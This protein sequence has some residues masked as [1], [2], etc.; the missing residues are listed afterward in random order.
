MKDVARTAGVSVMT[1][2]RVINDTGSVNEEMAE[3]VR[4]AARQLAFEPNGV[5][6]DLRN[7]TE[8]SMI[9]LVI[10]DLANPFYSLL[11]KT[12]EGVAREHDSLLITASSEED[13]VREREVVLELA[14]RRVAGLIVVPAAGSHAFLRDQ[15]ELG[16]PAVLV[17]RLLADVEADAVL[18]DNFGGA[19]RG[20]DWLL[21]RG[22][23]SIAVLGFSDQIHSVA[24]RLEGVRV[25]LADRGLALDP[26]L[27]RLGALDERTAAQGM[28][29]LLD[30]ANPPSAVFCSNNRMTI[31]AIQ[32]VAR[33]NAQVDIVGFDD[34]AFAEF[35]PVPVVLITYDIER[36]AS[37]AA[38]LL[39]SRIKGFA[40][41]PRT[42]TVPTSLRVHPASLWSA[43]ATAR[44]V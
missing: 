43:A 22:H 15:V 11:A 29:S 23:S 37:Q 12:V 13:S 27:V 7:G 14:R 20:A 41:P 30:L 33:R 16:T 5:A 10:E 2:S 26:G 31:G 40:G 17:D 36:L 25:A 8:Q 35:L 1:V 24:Q 3:R 34:V 39:F 18:I 4:A 6:R 44:Q 9:G 19:K 42:V 21:D 28:A 38:E 32:E